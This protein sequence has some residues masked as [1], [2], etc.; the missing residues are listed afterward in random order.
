MPW[1]FRYFWF[2]AAA[3]MTLNVVFVRGRLTPL[4][5]RGPVTRSEVDR[6]ALWLAAWF[7]VGPLVFGAIGLAAGWSSPFC[8]GM[9]EF[10]SGAQIALSIANVLIWA[11]VLWWIWRGTGAEFMSRAGPALG[12]QPDYDRRYSPR[13]VRIVGTA[14]ILLASLGALISWRVMPPAPELACP[15][16]TPAASTISPT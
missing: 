15:A 13:M 6:F 14:V 5:E 8:G 7:V 1:I 9:M 2:L 4:V 3:F 16:D 10:G 11:S 12:R